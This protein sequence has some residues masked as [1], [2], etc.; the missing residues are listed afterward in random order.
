M[1]IFFNDPLLVGKDAAHSQDE[2]RGF[3]LGQTSAGRMLFAVF[4]IRRQLIRVISARDM[5]PAERKRYAK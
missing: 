1:T 3:A 2:P 5:T 4:T